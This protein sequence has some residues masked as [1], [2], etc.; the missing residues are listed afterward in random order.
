M[1]VYNQT[2]E[3]LF[4]RLQAFHRVGATAYKPG[5][6]TTLALSEAFGSPHVGLR[7]IHVAGTNGK[8]S[9]AHTLAAVLQAC[10]LYTSPSPRDS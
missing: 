9:T 10:L 5:L 6:H 4:N 1:D 3:F 8:G 2:L 7:T